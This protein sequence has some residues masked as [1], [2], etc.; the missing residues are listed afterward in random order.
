MASNTYGNE[1]ATIPSR[2]PGRPNKTKPV[3][4]MKYNSAMGGVDKADQLAVYYCFQRKSLKWWKKVF[5]W[6]LETSV[7]NSFIIYKEHNTTC[8]DSQLTFRQKLVKALV[9]HLGQSQRPRPGRPRVSDSIER[10]QS[11]KH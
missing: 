7:V 1:S 5:F 11:G 10:L 4:V 9:K 8:K 6:L 2:V 3:V